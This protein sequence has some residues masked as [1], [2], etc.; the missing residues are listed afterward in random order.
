[1]LLPKR[2]RAHLLE[3]ALKGGILLDV[4]LVLDDSGGTNAA[5]L[6]SRQHQREQK[7]QQT[8]AGQHP[9]NFTEHTL[10][11]QHKETC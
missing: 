2:K 7:S 1:M 10:Q 6:H 9:E 4:L 8:E 5:E 11:L 3:S